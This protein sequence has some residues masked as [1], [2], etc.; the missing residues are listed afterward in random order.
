MAKDKKKKNNNKALKEEKKAKAAVKQAK[1]EKKGKSKNQEEDSDEDIEAILANFQREQLEKF[2]VA[3]EIVGEAPSFRGNATLTP[4]PLPNANEL[5]FFGGEYYDGARC[6]FYN[7]LFRYN[8]EKNEWKKIT[9]P[10]SPGP[11]SSHQ[12]VATPNGTMFLYG[13]E[14]ASANETKFFHYRVST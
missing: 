2:K 10:N 13:G 5:I 14:F 8:V 6:T 9:S 12:M 1:K 11:R 7:E 4:N 3:E